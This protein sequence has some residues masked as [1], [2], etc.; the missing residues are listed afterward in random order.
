MIENRISELS[1]NQT[2]FESEKAKYE[3]ALKASGYKHTLTYKL[4]QQNR[5]TLP[6]NRKRK[7]IWF[8]PPYNSAVKTNIAKEFLKLVDKHFP[9]NSPLHKYYTTETH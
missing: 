4:Q 5:N 6:K 7:V 8:N 1:S 2:I 3:K 9:K